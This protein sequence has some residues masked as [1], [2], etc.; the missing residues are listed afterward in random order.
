M[1]GYALFDEN[2][3]GTAIHPEMRAS[4]GTIGYEGPRGPVDYTI[5]AREQAPTS[6]SLNLGCIVTQ[7]PT[8]G[9]IAIFGVAG[10]AAWRRRG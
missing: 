7:D 5:W 1:P 8:S 9:A 4:F 3:V 2:H 10:L 6:D